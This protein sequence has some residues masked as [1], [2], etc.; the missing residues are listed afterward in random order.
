MLVAWMHLIGGVS[1]V[2]TTCILEFIEIIINTSI[3][4]NLELG[5]QL[6]ISTCPVPY[7]VHTAMFS[8]LIEPQII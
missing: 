8:L 7:D 5:L 1:R 2:T 4:T 6:A 3:Y